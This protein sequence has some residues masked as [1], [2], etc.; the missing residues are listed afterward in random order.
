VKHKYGYQAQLPVYS[1]QFTTNT[2]NVRTRLTPHVRYFANTS[3]TESI[4]SK[5]QDFPSRHCIGLSYPNHFGQY[6]I[7]VREQ[8]VFHKLIISLL[9]ERGN[10]YIASTIHIS[11]RQN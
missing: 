5:A 1:L 3:E 11:Y 9:F 6:T 2:E 8:Q 7:C 4:Y 10:R